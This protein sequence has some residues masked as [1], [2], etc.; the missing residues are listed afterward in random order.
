MTKINSVTLHAFCLI[1]K[2]RQHF[3]HV[4]NAVKKCTKELLAQGK[5]SSSL[6]SVLT[7]TT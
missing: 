6:L 4:N 2:H 5:R 7:N 3:Y 1:F